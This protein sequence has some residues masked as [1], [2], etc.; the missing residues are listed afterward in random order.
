MGDKYINSF[1]IEK[2]GH[3]IQEIRERALGNIVSKLNS[4]VLFDNDLARSK[5]LLDKLFKWF[6]FEPC[7]QEE[8]VLALIKRILKSK[9]G[10]TLTEH[11]GKQTI[12][13][14]LNNINTYLEPKFVPLLEDIIKEISALENAVPPLECDVPLSYRSATSL[15][16]NNCS[17]NVET[18][19]TTQEGY[20]H[21]GSS[22]EQQTGLHKL[23]EYTIPSV[24]ENSPTYRIEEIDSSDDEKLPN[25]YF[26]WQ[27]LIESDRHVLNSVENSLIN[28][29]QPS[30]LLHSCEFF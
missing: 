4:G 16:Q 27:P 20:L 30:S 10:Q 7:S 22:A 29:P 26:D 12:L 17:A 2:L 11:I 14:E 1:H 25:L 23:S 9:S 28:P 18:T 24:Y 15:V 19:A 3:K 21:K 8:I 5:E 6:L 13:N